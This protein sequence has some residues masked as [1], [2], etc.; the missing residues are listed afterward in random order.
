MNFGDMIEIKDISGKI[1]FS[2]LLNENSKF[3]EE[4]M[5]SDY[6]QLS[7]VSDNGAV[8]PISSYVEYN[9]EKYRLL[10]PYTPEMDNELKYVYTPIFHSRVMVWDK[11]IVP[12]Y[13]YSEDGNTVIGKEFDWSFTGSPVDAMYIIKQAIKNET[14]EDWSI[15]IGEVP[16]TISISSQSTS[17]LSMLNT[18]ASEC[19]TE[20]WADKKDNT[21]YLSKCVYGEPI[22]LEVG[23]NVQAPTVT[24]DNRGYFTRF[25]AFGSTRNITQDYDNGQATNHVVNKRLTLNPAKFPGGYKDIK[26]GLTANEIFVK[27]LYFDDVYPSSRLTISDVR[28]R[29]K[30]RLD[31]SG[32]KIKIGGTEEEPI[33]EQ[34][35][36]WFFQIENFTFNIDSIIEGKTLSVSFESG[37][38]AGREFELNYHN[39]AETVKDGNDVT[40]FYVKAG[41]FEIILDESTGTI[42]PGLSYI[43]PQNGDS[44]VLFNI[45]MPDEYITSAQNELEEKLDKEISLLI[46]DNNIYK[47]SSYPTVFYNN[48]IDIRMGQAVTFI[49][50]TNQLSTRVQAVEKRLDLPCYQTIKL[51]NKIMKGNT[52]QLKDEVAS[53]NQDLDV[54]KAFNELSNS[55]SNAYANAQ[56]EMIE[57]FAAI[58]ELWQLRVDDN[59]NQY[60][61]TKFDVLSKG[62]MT[63][64][65]AGTAK[66]PSIYEGIPFDNKTIWYNKETKVVEV[67]GGT[68]GGGDIDATKLWQLLSAPTEEQINES[69]LTNALKNYSTTTKMWE[70]LKGNT[71]EQIN[72]S[73]LTDVLKQ[74]T[75]TE[76]LSGK[77]V[78]T[79]ETEQSILGIKDFTKGIKVGGQL[80]NIVDGVLYLDCSIAVTGGIT[81]Y[82][83]GDRTPSTIMD[84]IV[85]DGTTI[86]KEGGIL[87]LKDGAG[88]GDLDAEKLWELLEA[89]GIQQ[90]DKSHLT[91]ALNG[92]ATTEQLN[93]KWTQDDVKISH[94][95]EA[96]TWG[97]HADAGYVKSKKVW[98]Q[99]YDG[100]ND[101]TG[102]MYNVGFISMNGNISGVKVIS[103]LTTHGGYN[104]H[105]GYQAN[106]A[107]RIDAYNSDG[108]W[109]SNLMFGLIN[110]RIGIGTATPTERLEVSGNVK[111]T[112]FNIN[113]KRLYV[114][115]GVVYLDGDLAVTGGITAYAQGSRSVS[116][117][118]DGVSVDGTTISKEGGYL[119]VIGGVG[120]ASNWDDLEGKPTWITDT[121]PSYDKL[122]S[123]ERYIKK[124]GDTATGNINFSKGLTIPYGQGV[125]ST[126]GILLVSSYDS[127]DGYEDYFQLSANG[128]SGKQ[129][130][131]KGGNSGKLTWNGNTIWH[132]G[133]D[134]ANSGLDADLLDGKQLHTSGQNPF[135]KIPFISGIDGG[136][137]FG[138]FIDFHT[139]KNDERDYA[140]R[141][142]A[143]NTNIESG[144][145]TVNLPTK[146]GTLALLTDNVASAD[147]LA[148]ARYIW[149]QPFN[150]TKNITGNMSDV[151]S[152]AMDGSLSGVSAINA[153]SSNG[154][155]IISR[156]YK[157]G[158]SFRLD[159]YNGNNDWVSNSIVILTSGYVGIGMINPSDR[160]HVNG[161]VRI[162]NTLY[163]NGYSISKNSDGY[164][165]LDGNIRVRGNILAEGGVTVYASSFEDNRVIDEV[166]G[167]KFSKYGSFDIDGYGNHRAT[168]NSNSYTWSVQKYNGTSA[169]IVRSVDGHVGINTTTLND[170][171]TVGG[172]TRITGN[173]VVDGTISG[174]GI[175][176]GSADFTELASNASTNLAITVGGTRK[177]ITNLYAYKA[178]ELTTS[179]T[180]WGQ[181]FNGGGNIASTSPIY[182]NQMRDSGDNY[183]FASDG[184]GNVTMGTTGRSHYI[185]FDTE[186]GTK[187]YI[188]NNGNV[189]IGTTSPSQKLHVYGGVLSITNMSNSITLGSQNALY[190]H[191]YNSA[192]IPFIMN[193]S[194]LNTTSKDI[195][196]NSYPWGSVYIRGSVQQVSDRRLKT[197]IATLSNRGFV[198]PV[199]FFMNN[200]K[201]IGLV[202]QDVQKLYPELVEEGDDANHTLTLNYSQYVAVL[203]AQIIE[204][205]ERI[206]KLEQLNS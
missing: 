141:L 110:G 117:I 42:I 34:Y 86:S 17:I 125:N 192:N 133:N 92:Y 35:A 99:L 111:A 162:N 200:K 5:T 137:E 121:N 80:I 102:N 202:A 43:I 183:C 3:V 115:G 6:I 90:I 36:I 101:I 206:K 57:G 124:A 50:K 64:Y 63:A 201:C 97:N 89:E 85:V 204:L 139:S 11:Q 32:N 33:Y 8:I 69:H 96:Y 199:T 150:G 103:S 13:T 41:D 131:L 180:I 164:L 88:S 113:G 72:E 59:G 198:N 171:L 152:I 173:L 12:V 28:A 38:L 156:G 37:Q 14:G 172:N 108:E 191:I 165:V 151:G 22:T 77:F 68:G 29:L 55:L 160:F 1:L 67:I 51:G 147:K 188:L 30:Y 107:F 4:L 140:I 66:V 197:D 62:G 74:Y 45:I 54:I 26:E 73:H 52:Q 106:E 84:G 177:T 128:A 126:Y 175:G 176:G 100:V 149:G 47:T 136:M 81:A 82:A 184:N 157:S 19:D 148:T 78:T 56:R 146:T 116:T 174:E 203:Q 168:V 145:F 93:K 16:A 25:Y 7:W 123:D 71:T 95:D 39:E 143:T 129:G 138:K 48:N 119:H 190:C 170:V 166:G 159:S 109:S 94:W 40:S 79:D 182:V 114:S 194:L 163:V 178:D 142:Q 127:T 21:L 196:D 135:G 187:M 104:L 46:Q 205:N 167:I 49:N 60:A 112:E 70:L 195:G 9:G 18:I 134:G 186:G 76:E 20:W 179:R 61:Y 27:V 53:V 161:N 23:N 58:K 87:H 2:V 98:G 193:N 10:E 118:M 83:M 44:V 185:K 155:Y 189:G 181:S 132:S 105:G 120:G 154:G 144:G 158:E 65:S 169:I 15:Q 122:E 130:I 31:N 91:T 24:N 153:F 75:K